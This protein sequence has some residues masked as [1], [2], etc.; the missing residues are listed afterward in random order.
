MK[1]FGVA[2][3]LGLLV[4]GVQADDKIATVQQELKDQGFYYG[5]I[6]GEKNA[7]TSAAI[8]RFQIRSGLQITGDLNDETSKALKSAPPSTTAPTVS[9]TVAPMT[10]PARVRATPTP[11]DLQDDSSD[12]E[13]P[14]DRFAAP[15]Q[16]R[17]VPPV[18]QGG[19]VPS[20]GGNFA[21]TPYANAPPPV[22]EDLIVRAQRKLAR[23]ELY[24]GDITG[25]FGP[26]LEFSLRA[27]QSRVGLPATGR[28]DLATLAAL[29]LLPGADQPVFTPRRGYRVPPGAQPPVRGEWIRP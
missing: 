29:E 8:R 17:Q 28:L 9:A 10:T 23:R 11:S 5:D 12:P 20:T 21:G 16:D 25:V 6:T 1:L 15:P 3:I 24:R 4:A 19:A 2:M 13:R 7:D 26:D 18:Y 27:Y 22:Q 14:P